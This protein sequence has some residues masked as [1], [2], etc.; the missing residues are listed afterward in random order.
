MVQ[1]FVSLAGGEKHR[2]AALLAPLL[3]LLLNDLPA[4]AQTD[5]KLIIS[6]GD[7]YA[8]GEGNPDTLATGCRPPPIFTP[9]PAP[10]SP[11]PVNPEIFGAVPCV[12]RAGWSG[13]DGGVMLAIRNSS[14]VETSRTPLG[15]GDTTCH[16]SRTSGPRMAADKFRADNPALDVWFHSLACSGATTATI[17]NTAS[18]GP[19]GAGPTVPP[20]SRQIA[21]LLNFLE[22][23]RGLAVSDRIDALVIS[24]G[25]NDIGFASMIRHCILHGNC[26]ENATPPGVPVPSCGSH[27]NIGAVRTCLAGRLDALAASIAAG[28]RSGPDGVAAG[29]INNVYLTEYPDLT[30]KEN[31]DYCGNRSFQDPVDG[32]ETP[33]ARW[34]SD[35]A[36]PALNEELRLVVERQRALGRS[37]HYVSGPMAA[38]RSDANGVGHGYCSNQPW[39]WRFNQAIDRQG[40]FTGGLHPR[41]EGHGAYRDALLRELEKLKQPK[42]PTNLRVSA[43]RSHNLVQWDGNDPA[44]EFYQVG[45]ILDFSYLPPVPL[46]AFLREAERGNSP[47]RGVVLAA[48]G[49]GRSIEFGRDW[50]PTTGTADMNLVSDIPAGTSQ[51]VHQR[52]GGAVYAVRACTVAACSEWSNKVW[53]RNL[54]PPAPTKLRVSAAG[55]SSITVAWESPILISFDR[56]EISHRRPREQEQIVTVSAADRQ[57]VIQSGWGEAR[58]IAVRTCSPGMCSRWSNAIVAY[59]LPRPEAAPSLLTA[60][61][62]NPTLASPTASPFAGGNSPGGASYGGPIHADPPG[63]TVS[64]TVKVE[65]PGGIRVSWSAVPRTLRYQLAV[66]GWRGSS[67]TPRSDGRMTPIMT[68]LLW[69]SDASVIVEALEPGRDILRLPAI[70][71]GAIPLNE[72]LVA[73]SEKE[74]PYS[75]RQRFES[76][77][78]EGYHYRLRACNDDGCGPWSQA[79]SLSLSGGEL[80]AAGT[81]SG[82]YVPA[83]FVADPGPADDP[84]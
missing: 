81:P 65:D 82:G 17:I 37:W 72:A 40:D 7:S 54:A 60:T 43:Q 32:I 48:P 75:W 20:Q 69:L 35:V 10:G 61:I 71:S 63:T 34:A 5:R 45:Y 1:P 57:A 76:G 25:G 28:F 49:T 39:I 2:L 8:S 80:P 11:A 55:E 27:L 29:R 38:S 73:G 77:G 4:A 44:T 41:A 9:P 18:N 13:S 78:A 53:A 6:L 36:I 70:V 42:A 56:F 66:M 15:G 31:G 33:E 84:P 83:S 59:A 46:P 64:G 50:M 58:I 51:W 67:S 19:L 74:L 26:H 16:R 3:L 22:S 12:T 52:T 21:R 62:E 14:G 68:R 47:L 79:V 30:R 24:I 23:D